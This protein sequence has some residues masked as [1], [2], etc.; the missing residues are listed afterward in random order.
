MSGISQ[1][2]GADLSAVNQNYIPVTDNT[3]DIG[4]PTATLQYIYVGSGIRLLNDVPLEG[5]DFAD[6]AWI[7]LIKIDP[8]DD[9]II[10]SLN[11]IVL[12]VNS[13][14]KWRIQS[15]TNISKLVF[16]ETDAYILANTSDGADTGVLWLL[17]G[18]DTNT[19]ARG[20]AVTIGGN[21]SAQPGHVILTSGNS[22]TSKIILQSVDSNGIE[23]KEGST[24]KWNMK[25][26]AAGQSTLM[27]TTG[28][29]VIRADVDS[30]ALTISGGGGFAAAN[31]ARAEIF[32][33]TSANAGRFDIFGANVANAHIN[34]QTNHATTKIGLFYNAV[35]QWQVEGSGLLKVKN[36]AFETTGANAVVL[37]ANSPATAASSPNTWLTFTKSDG[38][39]LYIPAW[40]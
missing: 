21:E 36:A 38:T 33:A 37:G 1:G 30:S 32:G 3:F 28:S 13:V 16:S 27:F 10:D 25:D 11:D 39:V 23:F 19:V 7:P 12:N 8:S 20:G 15:A 34:L 6:A 40:A 9:T 26:A 24:L 35:E 14:E 29:G 22:G 4:S 2:G 5:R 31:G 17:G 18:G